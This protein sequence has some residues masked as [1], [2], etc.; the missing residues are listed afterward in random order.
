MN[1]SK[2]SSLEIK[3]QI[4]IAD[5]LY[6]NAKY[7]NAIDVFYPLLEADNISMA[8]RCKVYKKL[9]Y[10]FYKLKDFD[11]A[12]CVYE[13]MLKFCTADAHTYDM[14]GY[15]YFYRDSLSFHLISHTHTHTQ[16]GPL[17]IPAI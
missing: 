7:K 13:Q 11:S 10:S 17:F 1:D 2:I 16:T 14:L 12:I 5:E 8:D 6:S 3:E 4:K 9:G 15:L